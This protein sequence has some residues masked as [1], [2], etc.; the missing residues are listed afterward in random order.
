MGGVGM[1]KPTASAG[2]D[3]SFRLTKVVGGIARGLWGERLGLLKSDD[4]IILA[5]YPLKLCCD[6]P[7]SS[8]DSLR[9]VQ[10]RYDGRYLFRG[11]LTTS[12]VTSFFAML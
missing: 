8:G 3:F 7:R 5:S 9:A 6:I 10:R 2:L 4:A 12:G 1:G 11:G